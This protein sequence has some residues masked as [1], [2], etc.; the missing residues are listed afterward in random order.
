MRFDFYCENRSGSTSFIFTPDTLYGRGLGGAEASLVALTTELAKRGHSVH[1]W[2]SPASG[3]G[4]YDGVSYHDVEDFDCFETYDVFVCYRNPFVEFPFIQARVRAWWS[5]DQVT[6]GDYALDI[7]PFSQLNIC[8]SEYHR[9]HHIKVYGFDPRNTI[10]IDLGVRVQ[11]YQKRLLKTP[12][13]LLYCSVP[14][15]GLENLA[16]FFPAIRH[17]VPDATLHITS[18]YALWGEGIPDNN[19]HYI[20]LFRNMEGVTF[21]S[22]VP[23]EKLVELQLQSELMAY[24]N[25]PVGGH[26]ELFGVSVAECQVAGCVPVTSAFG[27]FTTTV[28][29]P[30]GI[31]ITADEEPIHP[32][33]EDYG[34]RFILQCIE[35]LFDRQELVRRQTALSVKASS[36]FNWSNIA[37]QWEQAIKK[38]YA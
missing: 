11:D 1:V 7:K 4:V 21:H 33:D 26:A 9:Q 18:S 13:S 31:L 25:Q 38:V 8:I 2:N 36:R 16:R 30:E 17:I 27:A 3:A 14:D 35:L 10:A 12:N 22:R 34:A 28:I 15:R 5:T 23:R 20:K 37:S 19:E 32:S 24:P 29:Q 6:C